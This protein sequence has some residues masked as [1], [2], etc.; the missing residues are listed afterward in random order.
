MQTPLV[1]VQV[2]HGARVGVHA[3]PL[4][5]LPA[6]PRHERSEVVRHAELPHQVFRLHVEEPA[7]LIRGDDRPAVLAVAKVELFG[8]FFGDVARRDRG[9]DVHVELPHWVAHLF[10]QSAPGP[11]GPGCEV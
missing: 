9:D 4:D 1:L 8:G 5:L 10:L 6:A 3:N 11:R 2:V 7:V